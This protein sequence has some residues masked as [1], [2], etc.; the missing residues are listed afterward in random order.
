M[1]TEANGIFSVKSFDEVTVEELID[2]TRLT[3][4]HIVQTVT[5]DLDG[6]STADYVMY[7]RA[8][9][10]ASFA[11]FQ[12]FV[13][14]VRD[15]YGS[16]VQQTTGQYDNDQARAASTVVEGSGD[17]DLA[18]FSGKGTWLAPHGSTGSYTLEYQTR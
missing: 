11:G 17:G 14:S 16:F 7:Y 3:R 4:A 6:E 10:T 18:G 13:G 9:G 5:G 1:T 8:D 12:R 15:S 2:G